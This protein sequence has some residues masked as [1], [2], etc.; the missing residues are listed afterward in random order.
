MRENYK[1]RNSLSNIEVRVMKIQISNKNNNVQ[2]SD[3]DTTTQIQID[4]SILWIIGATIVIIAAI[5]GL[6][7]EIGVI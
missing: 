2:V 3:D 5:A 1:Y 4:S 7:M 6:A